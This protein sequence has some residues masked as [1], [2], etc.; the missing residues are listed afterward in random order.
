MR[1]TAENFLKKSINQSRTWAEKKPREVSMSLETGF[2]ERL[3]ASTKVKYFF[4]TAHRQRAKMRGQLD[5]IS[6]SQSHVTIESLFSQV[7][8]KVEAAT[9]VHNFHLAWKASPINLNWT[10]NHANKPWLWQSLESTMESEN[11]CKHEKNKKL[12]SQ[13]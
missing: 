8:F 13:K 4:L 1:A 3:G 2:S 12:A 11:I 6:F 9:V 7:F 10:E 5:L